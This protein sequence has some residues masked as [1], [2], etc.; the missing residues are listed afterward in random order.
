VRNAP[1]S[2]RL[3]SATRSALVFAGG[4]ATRLGGTNKALLEVGGTPIINRILRAVAPLADERLLL[5]NDASLECIGG[6]RLV[7]DPEPHAGVLPALAAG[8]AAASTETC[9]CMACDMPFVSAALFEHL[10]ERQIETAADVVIPRT[11]GHLEPMHAIYRRA[12]ALEAIH[13]S[14]ARGEQRMVSYFRDLRVCEVDEPEWRQW[15]PTGLAFF[16]VNTRQDL[17]AAQSLALQADG[18]GPSG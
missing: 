10:L 8:L 12:S 14:L 2:T 17:E 6:L 1:E 3:N 5:T 18:A 9:L 4:R 15:D 11:A 7:F 16:N 13:G